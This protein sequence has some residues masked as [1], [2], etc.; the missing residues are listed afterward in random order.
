MNHHT[1]LNIAIDQRLRYQAIQD[2]YKSYVYVTNDVKIVLRF[3]FSKKAAAD[4][5][6]NDSGK[7]LSLP[8]TRDL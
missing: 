2:T 8:L 6:P 1:Q 4:E 3:H 7:E 5:N